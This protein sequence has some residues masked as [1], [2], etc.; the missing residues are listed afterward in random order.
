MKLSTLLF[1]IGGTAAGIHLQSKEGE[2]SRKKL[3]KHIDNLTPLVNDVFKQ[4]EAVLNDSENVESDEIRA[5]VEKTVSN[6]KK[7]IEKVDASKV[8]ETTEKAIKIASQK[9]RDL[10]MQVASAKENGNKPLEKM[11]V[12]QL[13]NKAKTMEITISSKDKKANLIKK[14]QKKQK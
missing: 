6:V 2:D 10:K 3:K 11:T 4:L 14:I 5:N 1:L 13:K 12:S 8:G 7:T 9:I